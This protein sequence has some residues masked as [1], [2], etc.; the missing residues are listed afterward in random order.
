MWCRGASSSITCPRRPAAPRLR[1]R[2]TTPCETASSWRSTRTTLALSGNPLFTY[3]D[4]L[5][6]DD[7]VIALREL[8][9]VSEE[10][11]VFPLID[12]TGVQYPHLDALRSALEDEFLGEPPVP[13][14]SKTDFRWSWTV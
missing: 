1:P 8:L 4:R 10:V 14:F 5:S 2:S 9:R 7:H 12:I 3:A 6:F 13:V 11:R